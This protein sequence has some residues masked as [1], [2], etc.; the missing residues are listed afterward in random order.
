MSQHQLED[1]GKTWKDVGH[2]IET[3]AES[4]AAGLELNTILHDMKQSIQNMAADLKEMK[5][6][7]IT[8]VINSTCLSPNDR[9]TWINVIS[10]SVLLILFFIILIFELIKPDGV[11]DLPGH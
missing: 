6:G 5:K 9:I 11:K 10:K 4:M 8:R 7:T 3:N 1:L 2:K